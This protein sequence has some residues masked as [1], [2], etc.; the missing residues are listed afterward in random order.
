MRKF[1]AAIGVAGALVLSAAPA[2]AASVALDRDGAVL[3]PGGV[4][5][6]PPCYA[7]VEYFRV[8]ASIQNTAPFVDVD[9]EGNVGGHV[10]CPI[11]DDPVGELEMEH[12]P[13]PTIDDLII[14][15]R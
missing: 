1:I 13:L 9:T 8:D 11:A 3:D 5:G 7:S 10:V 4:Y 12:E 2:H 14:T 6:A 15:H